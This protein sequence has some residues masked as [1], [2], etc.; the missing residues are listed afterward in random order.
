MS[1]ITIAFFVMVTVF[2]LYIIFKDMIFRGAPDTLPLTPDQKKSDMDLVCSALDEAFNRTLFD[3]ASKDIYFSENSKVQ[4]CVRG[5]YRDLIGYLLRP[6]ITFEDQ[7]IIQPV[8]TY[9]VSKVYVVY[10][11]ET[12]TFIKNLLFKYY[13]GFSS[14]NYFTKKKKERPSALHFI[15]RYVTA[16]LWQRYYEN[17]KR[18]AELY[19]RLQN[20]EVDTS[21]FTDWLNDYDTECICKL[22]LNIYDFYREPE[23]LKQNNINEVNNELSSKLNEQSKRSVS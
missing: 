11:S 14:S 18:I 20:N 7:G 3:F 5:R 6:D 21:K 23:K 10:I 2:I 13:S 1:Y 9:F 12:S 15:T 8:L 22:S 16:K 17:E 19:V 4:M